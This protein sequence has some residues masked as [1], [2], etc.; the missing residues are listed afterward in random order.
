MKTEIVA[1]G[2]DGVPVAGI[3]VEL[4]LTQIQW[5]SVRR[6]EGGGFYTWDTKRTEIPIGSWTVTTG[7]EPIPFEAALPNGGNFV[8]TATGR[9]DG[10]LFAV[11][12]TSFYALGDGYT[13]WARFDHNRIELVPERKTWKPGDTARIMIQ[14]P[15]EQATALLTTER[16]G[17]RTYR[18]FA[19]TSTQQSV[20]VPITEADIPNVFVSV[21]LVKGRTKAVAA[22]VPAKS[23]A[24]IE[25]GDTSDPGKPAF[26]LGYVELKVEDA[27]KRLTVAVK[28]NKDEYRPANA[29]KVDLD[30]KDR[31]GRGASS[32]VTLWAVDYGVLSLTAYSTPDILRSVYVEKALQVINTDNRQRIVSRRVLTPKGSTD[33]GGGGGDSGAGTIRKDFRVLAFWLGSIT[34]DADGHASVDVKLPESLTTYRIMAVA[35]DRASRFGSGDSEVRIN[36]PITM[37]PTYRAS[38]PSATRRSSARSSPVSFRSRAPRS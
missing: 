4:K 24:T 17:I 34:T 21:L 38:W 25:E 11:T 20:T 3:P 29:A 5:Q 31:Q 26:R 16:E 9:G 13:A 27:T 28:A 30:V 7:S 35:A 22:A 15:W 8:L 19:L 12:R 36:K 6:A 32:E 1:V 10:A 33:G 23:P 14:S 37:K 2:L 18:Q